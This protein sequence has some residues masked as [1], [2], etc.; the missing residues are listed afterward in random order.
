MSFKYLE[1][2]IGWRSELQN[3]Q[4][5]EQYTQTYYRESSLEVQSAAITCAS[6]P[7]CSDDMVFTNYVNIIFILQEKGGKKV[8]IH[9][10]LVLCA[11]Y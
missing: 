1:V 7:S 2:R 11:R 5:L 6:S 10:V 8:M 3:D 9:D 4:G